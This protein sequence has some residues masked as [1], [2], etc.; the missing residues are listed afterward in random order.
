MGHVGGGVEWG[1]VLGGGGRERMGCRKKT[2]AGSAT[3][4]VAFG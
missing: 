3:K 1:V 4:E 2:G